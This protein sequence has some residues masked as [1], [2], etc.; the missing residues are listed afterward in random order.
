MK[1]NP[2]TPTQIAGDELFTGRDHELLLITNCLQQTIGGNATGFLLTGERGIGKSSLLLKVQSSVNCN[3]KP[4]ERLLTVLIT[5][6]EK[7]TALSFAEKVNAALI[8]EKR[9]LQPWRQRIYDAWSVIYRIETNWFKIK[10][11]FKSSDSSWIVI[12]TLADQIKGVMARF[13]RSHIGLLLLVDE[14]E[15]ASGDLKLG[16]LLRRL[17]EQLRKIG[18][19]KATIGL[20]GQLAAIDKLNS[21]HG[22]A[23]RAFR[24]VKVERLRLDECRQ[25]LSKGIELASVRNKQPIVLDDGAANWIVRTSDGY[26]HFLQQFA[27]SALD[28]DKDGT[29]S[30]DDAY[31]G[32]FGANG[33]IDQLG[34]SYFE[35]MFNV[36]CGSDIERLVLNALASETE[37]FLTVEEIAEFIEE[38]PEAVNS[39][40][41]R[42]C[43]TGIVERHPVRLESCR[44]VSRAFATWIQIRRSQEA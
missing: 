41:A 7:D 36:E 20:A 10:P 5:L 14:V 33:A 31:N 22:S 19:N 1:H 13:K 3:R 27:A 11:P 12:D 38:A 9:L 23:I 44:V 26:P 37:S 28:A 15:R 24:L 32:A 42:L 29:I 6:D 8:R 2:F 34:Y 43:E 16:A 35:G 18:V 4:K 40:V 25:A 21:D 39:A 17:V 30:I